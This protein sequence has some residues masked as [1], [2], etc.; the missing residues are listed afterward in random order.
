MNVIVF[1]SKMIR[2]ARAAQRRS[3]Q[4]NVG[5]INTYRKRV[6]LKKMPSPAPVVTARFDLSDPVL[7][8][9]PQFV[10]KSV[11]KPIIDSSRPTSPTP[12]SQ[13][14]RPWKE[15]GRGR[16]FET[17]KV[18]FRLAQPNHEAVETHKC[19]LQRMITSKKL[20]Q[21]AALSFES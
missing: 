7:F 4:I 2:N 12:S 8:L 18:H 14:P 6:G 20:Y 11:E 15:G 5:N 17:G 3:L 16:V 1:D 13:P 19:G 10:S 9:P 21:R